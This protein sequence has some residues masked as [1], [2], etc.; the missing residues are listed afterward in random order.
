MTL[1]TKEHLT[2]LREYI[3]ECESR[4]EDSHNEKLLEILDRMED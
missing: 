1:E 4:D 3:E 2:K